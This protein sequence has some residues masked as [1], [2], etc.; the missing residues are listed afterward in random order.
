M[1]CYFFFLANAN[2]SFRFYQQILLYTS[3]WS[4]IKG[5]DG[6]LLC[7]SNQ[8]FEVIDTKHPSGWKMVKLTRIFLSASSKTCSIARRKINKTLSQ[9]SCWQYLD[10][11]WHTGWPIGRLFVKDKLRKPFFWLTM[12]KFSIFIFQIWKKKSGMK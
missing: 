1:A 2:T 10:L 4:W 12:E 5:A 9:I 8:K 3:Y 11:S 6:G 7:I